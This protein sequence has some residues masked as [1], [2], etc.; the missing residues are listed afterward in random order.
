MLTKKLVLYFT[1]C[2]TNPSQLDRSLGF[3]TAKHLRGKSCL[4]VLIKT[5][6]LSMILKFSYALHVR[7]ATFIST[8]FFFSRYD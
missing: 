2:F 7:L 8:G 6:M 3:G 1:Q 4:G 5:I